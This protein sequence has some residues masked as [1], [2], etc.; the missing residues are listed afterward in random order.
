M[1]LTIREGGWTELGDVA[2]EIRRVVFIDEQQV[3][4]EE[5][6][7]GLDPDCRHFLALDTEGRPLGTARLLPDGH[8]GRVAVFHEARGQGV[9]QA[10]MQ[11][12]IDTAR[13]RGDA[14]VMLAAQ[15]QALPFYERLGFIA[16][17]E[18]FMEA[19]IAHRNM[20]LPL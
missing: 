4:I 16:E 5:E 17:G 19:G 20:S 18:T 9:G 13:R 3:P 10:L 2:G 7:D 15:I 6:W 12:A 14:R 8:I 1:P 11:A